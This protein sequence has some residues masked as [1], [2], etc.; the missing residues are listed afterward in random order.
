MR[1]TL[2]EIKFNNPK[3]KNGHY[4]SFAHNGERY[5]EFNLKNVDILKKIYKKNNKLFI[6]FELDIDSRQEKM[7][8]KIETN[9]INHVYNKYKDSLSYEDV[10]NNFIPSTKISENNEK[11]IMSLEVNKYCTFLKNIIFED[12]TQEDYKI[13]EDNDSVDVKIVF[14][15]IIFGKSSFKNKYMIKSITKYIEPKLVLDN[16]ILDDEY[17]KE[18][19]NNE[20]IN[21]SVKKNNLDFEDQEQYMDND[22]KKIEINI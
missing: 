22:Y 13:I 14:L 6:D 19:N 9:T 21:D 16:F 10:E 2:S 17:E 15:G 12:E 1:E 3:N 5:I 20:K 4:I 11:I 8:K 18:G 7:I